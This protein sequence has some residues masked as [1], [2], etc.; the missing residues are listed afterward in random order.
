[1]NKGLLI[2]LNFVSYLFHKRKRK[3]TR[4]RKSDKLQLFPL[5][6]GNSVSGKSSYKKRRTE[7]N[8][9]FNSFSFD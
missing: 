8:Y 6:C 7:E 3:Y 2:G 9:R 1:M 5:F 4:K